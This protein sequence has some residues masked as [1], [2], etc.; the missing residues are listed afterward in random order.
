MDALDRV[1]VVRAIVDA[2]PSLV[3]LTAEG[4]CEECDAECNAPVNVEPLHGD[5]ARVAFDR[6]ERE[7]AA[8][9]FVIV[10]AP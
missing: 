8:A 3:H 5:R 1:R 2:V 6:L 4:W 7:L 9:G 10:R